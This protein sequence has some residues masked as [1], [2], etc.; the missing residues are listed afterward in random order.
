MERHKGEDLLYELD[1]NGTPYYAT[2]EFLSQISEE[3]NEFLEEHG[4]DAA[5][6]AFY[7]IA[8]GEGTLLSTQVD[9]WLTQEAASV[10]GQTISQ[11]RTVVKAFLAWAGN[12]VLVED[13]NRK[14]AGEYV[15]HLLEPTS[16]ISRRT[17]KRYLSSLSS[18]WKWLEG[19]GFAQGNPWLGHGVG[20]KA[21]RGVAKERSQWTDDALI[22]VLSGAYTPRYTAIIHD[23]VRLALVT[24]A[25]KEDRTLCA[26]GGRRE[27]TRRRVVDNY[28]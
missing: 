8:K 16:G 10:T 18:F 21:A 24:G 17:A 15:G 1:P 28:S 7:R 4:G 3:A 26:E 23:L 9:G 12:D 27:Q 6:T 14:R 25:S 13:V 11:H 2:D 5:V 19:R 20:K 22:K